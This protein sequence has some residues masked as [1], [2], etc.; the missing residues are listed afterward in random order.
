MEYLVTMDDDVRP[1]PHPRDPAAP[2]SRQR[3]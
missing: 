3:G 1:A 2:G